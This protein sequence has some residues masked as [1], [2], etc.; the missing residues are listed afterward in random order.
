MLEKGCEPLLILHERH[1][2]LIDSSS[3]QGLSASVVPDKYK[4]IVNSWIESSRLFATPRSSNDDWF[5]LFGAAYLDC[6][7]ITNDEMRDHHFKVLSER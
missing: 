1:L 6:Q 4:A 3:H 5:W 7:V 2:D